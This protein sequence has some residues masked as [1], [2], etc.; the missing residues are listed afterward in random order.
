RQHACR[1]R[2]DLGVRRRLPCRNGR[3]VARVDVMLA[4]EPIA[5]AKPAPTFAW[6]WMVLAAMSVAMLG[7]YFGFDTIGALAPGLRRQM[8]YTDWNI[9]LLQASYSLPNIFVLLAVGLVID[10]IGAKRSMLAFA[11]IVFAGL[12]LTAVTSQIGVM[13]AGRLIFG[14][15][16]E[17]LAM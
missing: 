15:G 4:D 16:G 9:G 7:S 14:I 11:T 1:P 2:A 3:R 5:T 17:S 12:A 8:E 6:R 13:A 10:R